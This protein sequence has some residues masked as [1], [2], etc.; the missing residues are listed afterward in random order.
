[1]VDQDYK[2]SGV[3]IDLYGLTIQVQSAAVDFPKELIRPFR[4]FQKEKC[5]FRVIIHVEQ[6]QP[7]Y[8]T[9][10]SI[11]ASYSTPRNIV[12]KDKT[13]KII[14]YFGKGVVIESDEKTRYKIFGQNTDFK[15]YFW[16]KY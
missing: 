2:I 14:D 5:N 10:P 6:T 15:R 16:P 9:F 12:F 8:D 11:R 3:S 4:F 7:P 13:C 1:M